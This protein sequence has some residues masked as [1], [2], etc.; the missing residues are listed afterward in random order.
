[1]RALSARACV[2]VCVC[3][4]VW[5]GGWV[6]GCTELQLEPHQQLK[7]VMTAWPTLLRQFLSPEEAARTS[8][9]F[10]CAFRR[11]AFLSVAAERRMRDDTGVRLLSEEAMHRVQ[12]GV[13]PCTED[14]IAFLGSLRCQLAFGDY[15]P[16]VRGQPTSA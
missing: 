16:E 12:S 4:C 15:N 1:M 5:V 7:A 11:R 10:E 13:Y 2:C 8:T 3:V 6:C 14:D 9:H